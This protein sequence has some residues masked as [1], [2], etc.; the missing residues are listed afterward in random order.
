MSGPPRLSVHIGDYLKDTPPVSRVNWEHHGIYLLSF[1]IA[2]N[3]PGCRLPTDERWLSSRFGCT[4]EELK[5]HVLPVIATY[6]KKRGAFWYQ[7]RLSEEAIYNRKNGEKQA[8]RAKSMWRNKK[9]QASGM[10]AAMPEASRADAAS[11]APP[12]L[13]PQ[14][15]RKKETTTTAVPPT[16]PDGMKEFLNGFVVGK[17]NGNGKHHPDEVTLKNPD[18]RIARFQKTIANAIG[19]NGWII[20]AKAVNLD[21]PEHDQALEHC[22]AVTRTLKKGWPHNWPAQHNGAN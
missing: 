7:K 14:Q 20:V 19:S 11:Y 21:D 18:E 2:W 1:F 3:T 10:S 6:Y 13:T 5:K 4:V 17:K 16:P 12:S 22:K 8:S 15:E 9:E